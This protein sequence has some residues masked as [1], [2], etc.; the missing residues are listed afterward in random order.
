MVGV[1]LDPG[2]YANITGLP[3]L[4]FLALQLKC[5]IIIRKVI[6]ILISNSFLETDKIINTFFYFKI[7]SMDSQGY[8]PGYL[9]ADQ[10]SPADGSS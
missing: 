8:L 7:T 4:V 5:E 10:P 3:G 1:P 2:L 6:L 9:C